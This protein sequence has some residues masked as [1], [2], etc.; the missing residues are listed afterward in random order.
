MPF[1]RVSRD[2]RGYEQ[3]SLIHA[4]TR[5]GKPSKP[6]VLY[7]FRTPPGVKL[8]REP[9][10]E[11]IR[12][13]IE[14]QHPDVHFDWVQLSKIPVPSPDVEYWRERRRAEKAAKQAR[15]EAD[16]E[17]SP[18]EG[19][20][21]ADS[22]PVPEPAE[23]PDSDG[24]WAGPDEELTL[25]EAA[26]EALDPVD[27][28]AGPGPEDAAPG[29]GQAPG[30]EVTAN[31]SPEAHSGEAAPTGSR[32]RRRRGGRRRHKRAAALTSSADEPAGTK[33]ATGPETA[34]SP[35]PRSEPSKMPEDS[36]KEA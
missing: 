26:I 7:V 12:R 27:D 19:R 9:F 14:E 28:E 13:E 2:K 15:R 18:A 1:V 6:R 11:S 20:E 17:E 3:I 21:L 25:E 5:R 31:L 8:G 30:A 33:P 4:S 34:L 32:R 24:D 10:D 36:S 29:D 35:E 16:R 23:A 22:L